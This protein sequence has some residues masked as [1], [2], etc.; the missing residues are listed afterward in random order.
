LFN[1][2]INIKHYGGNKM[3]SL[4]TKKILAL[5][6]IFSLILA[7]G[8]VA[9]AD[10]AL[11][12]ISAYQNQAMKIT[13]DGKEIDS[14][15]PEGVLYPIV[16]EGHSYV[17]A[18]AVAE[19]LGASVTWNG[20][21]TTVEIS[22]STGSVGDAVNDNT[23]SKPIQPTPT[24][25]PSDPP[26]TVDNTPVTKDKDGVFILASKEETTANLKK[27]A[28][29]L[30]KMYADS[31]LTKDSSKFGEY[32][33]EHVAKPRDN[34]YIIMDLSHYKDQ[35]DKHVNN[36][37]SANNSVTLKKYAET[38]KAVTL[39][40]IVLDSVSDKTKVGQQFSFSSSPKGWFGGVHVN[41]N[42]TSDN[43]NSDKF[44]L[45]QVDVG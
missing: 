45:Y 7:M 21:T 16:Y 22:S 26:T 12:K 1:W 17:S 37:I 14:S 23:G 18:K 41:F 15:S 31:L 28:V 11:K 3:K 4:F 36:T 24:P 25:R 43:F 20:A 6:T 5:V 32:L 34:S 19:A 44:L 39:A 9:Y 2:G 35:Y 42:F 13:V 8:A 10:S 40:D 27:Q 38:L 29:V 30:I 33:E